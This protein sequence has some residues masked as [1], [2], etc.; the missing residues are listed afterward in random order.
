MS[1]LKSD[2]ATDYT[3]E[4]EDRSEAVRGTEEAGR[5]QGGQY[6]VGQS[7]PNIGKENP[8]DCNDLGPDGF[9][10]LT[11]KF[12]TQEVDEA[13]RDIN[14]GDVL[15]LELTGELNEETKIK[16]EDVVVILKKGKK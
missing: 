9:D 8:D 1:S 3:A 15:V 16:G 5:G 4:V 7:K 14:D 11:L 10:D 12:D 2:W 13:L 6:P